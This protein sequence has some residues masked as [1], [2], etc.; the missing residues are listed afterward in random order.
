MEGLF[1]Y[2]I[3]WFSWVYLTFVLNKQNPYR[4]KSAACLLFIIILSNF[5]FVIGSF[6]IYAGGLVLLL[7]SYYFFSK[8]KFGHLLY[9]FICSFTITMAYVTF[10]LF[11]IFDPIWIIFKKEW[12]MG[13]CFSILAILLQKTLSGRLLIIVSGTMQGEVLYGYYLTKFNFSY[14]IGT[15]AYLDVCALI[16]LLLISWSILENAS[17]IFQNHIHLFEKGKQKSS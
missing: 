15:L 3:F 14:P 6:D 16:S 12:M 1:F 10:H 4:M 5:H 2:W 8:E 11:E 17:T 7:L 13:I 9:S